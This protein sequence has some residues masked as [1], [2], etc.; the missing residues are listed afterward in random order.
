MHEREWLTSTGP[1]AML[2]FLRETGALSERKARLFAV[3]CCRRFWD[4]LRDE[5]SRRAVEVAE[6]FADG[7]AAREELLATHD[8]AYS[9]VDDCLHYSPFSE[10]QAIAAYGCASE[11]AEAAAWDAV[12]YG[13][14]GDMRDA[15]AKKAT[16]LLDLFGPLPFR[17]VVLPT[18]HPGV[19]RRPRREAGGLHL[20][21]AVATRG[22]TGLRTVG[23]TR[24]CVGGRGL[25]G[26]RTSVA[27]PPAGGEALAGLLGHR[28]DSGQG[29]TPWTNASGWSA[30]TPRRC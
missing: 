10:D 14:D 18:V 11:E 5:R 24:G 1:Q 15:D 23:R 29:V 2:N 20:R 7:G 25:H 9:A 21:G 16:L 30:T 12:G 8:L 28:R 13:W 19:G 17:P 6:R 27:L 4:G 22:H 3:A 26:R